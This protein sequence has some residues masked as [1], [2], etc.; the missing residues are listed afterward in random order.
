MNAATVNA[1]WGERVEDVARALGSGPDGL[2]PGEAAR[3][4]EERG[5][6]A[7]EA[8]APFSS[9]RLVIDQVKSPL[10]RRVA[11][12]LR[13]QAHWPQIVRDQNAAMLNRTRNPPCGA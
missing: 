6:N 5:P 11:N 10:I 2:D 4:L 8:E 1:F 3:R 13:A 7:V 12:G 9:L